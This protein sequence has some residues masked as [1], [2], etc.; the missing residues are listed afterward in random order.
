MYFGFIVDRALATAVERAPTERHAPT[1]AGDLVDQALAPLRRRRRHVT[2]AGF[3]ELYDASVLVEGKPRA[4]N[5]LTGAK[6]LFVARAGDDYKAEVIGTITTAP[7]PGREGES[8]GPA[9]GGSWRSAGREG[10]S[11]RLVILFVG[12]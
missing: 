6:Q 12:D 10:R 9:S 5:D 4:R 7:Q 8:G 11:S 2:S 1:E 3:E